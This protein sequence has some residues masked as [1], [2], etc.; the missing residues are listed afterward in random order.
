MSDEQC[1]V[2]VGGGEL[3]ALFLEGDGQSSRVT[4]IS[5]RN[6]S[7]GTPTTST[8]RLEKDFPKRD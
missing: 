7:L 5:T 2:V 1:V 6:W 4:V 8:W 3:I